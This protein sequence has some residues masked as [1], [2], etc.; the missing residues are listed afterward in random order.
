MRPWWIHRPAEVV[1]GGETLARRSAT[2]FAGWTGKRLRTRA[3]SSSDQ[4]MVSRKQMCASTHASKRT[5]ERMALAKSSVWRERGGKSHLQHLDR[6]NDNGSG[7]G[8]EVGAEA[9]RP[10]GTPR[11]G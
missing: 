5:G 11:S 6:G 8:R 7:G 9:G 10:R 2:S 3:S 4:G 1:G